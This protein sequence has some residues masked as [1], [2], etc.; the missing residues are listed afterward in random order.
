MEVALR[1][2]TTPD[3]PNVNDKQSPESP[4][5]KCILDRQNPIMCYIILERKTRYTIK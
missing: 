2:A 5:E 4:E 1:M 3:P